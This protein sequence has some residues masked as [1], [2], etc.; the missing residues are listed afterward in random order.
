[1]AGV[2]RSFANDLNTLTLQILSILEKMIKLGFYQ[3]ED[4]I[5]KIVN[6]IINLLDGSNDF[7]SQIEENAFLE[8]QKKQAA[9][10][11]AGRKRSAFDDKFKRDKEKRYKLCESNT[12]IFAIKKKIIKILSYI[13][14]IQNDIRLT[15]FL[16]EFYKSDN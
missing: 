4:E 2:Q 8:F 6:T 14:D 15:K 3:K 13:I 12:V 16:V 10:E 1:M 9:D 5:V 7:T 11:A